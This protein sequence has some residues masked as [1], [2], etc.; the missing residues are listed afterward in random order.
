MA[1]VELL[2]HRPTHP[3]GVEHFLPFSYRGAG[4]WTGNPD[5]PLQSGKQQKENR[6]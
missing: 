4:E 5:L 2:A 1:K 3:L 6:L